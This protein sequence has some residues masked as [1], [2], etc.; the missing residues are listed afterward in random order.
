MGGVIADRIDRRKFMIITQIANGLIPLALGILTFTG[1]IAVWHIY[2]ASFLNGA[3][4]SLASRRA[5]R[6][7]RAW[8][9][10]STY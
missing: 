1:Q 3:V 6:W 4:G 9:P 10:A 7:C 2:L 8:C 5:W